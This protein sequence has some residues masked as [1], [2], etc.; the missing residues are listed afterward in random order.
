V[1]RGLDPAAGRARFART[2]EDPE[3]LLP[4]PAGLPEPAR[5][6]AAQGLV[7]SLTQPLVMAEPFTSR[8]GERTPTG[9]LLDAEAA[10]LESAFR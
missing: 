2:V 7:R 1:P 10:I 5:A 3:L 8:P 9:E 4:D 6:A